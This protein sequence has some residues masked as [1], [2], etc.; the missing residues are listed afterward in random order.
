MLDDATR[1]HWTPDGL[2]NYVCEEC[3]QPPETHVLD[4][5]GRM[6]LWCHPRDPEPQEA[7]S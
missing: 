7:Q 6:G 5:A 3:A 2:H 4:E 1:Q